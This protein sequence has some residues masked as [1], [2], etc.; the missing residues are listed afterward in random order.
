MYN[1]EPCQNKGNNMVKIKI[2]PNLFGLGLDIAEINLPVEKVVGKFLSLNAEP[3]LAGELVAWCLRKVLDDQYTGGNAD[4]AWAKRYP[5]Y[6][7]WLFEGKENIP[8]GVSWHESITISAHIAEALTKFINKVPDDNLTKMILP[9]L[10]I[11]RNYLKRHYNPEFKGFGLNTGGKYRGSPGIS[12]DNR[13]T[14]WAMMALWYLGIEDDETNEI[15]HNAAEFIANKLNPFTLDE[16]YTLTYA[17]FHK[18]LS[19]K[20]LSSVVIPSEKLRHSALKR[21]EGAIIDKYVPQCGSWDPD[22]LLDDPKI[23]IT[24]AL[25][26]LEPIQISSC[27]DK[28]CSEVLQK[29]LDHMCEKNLITLDDKTMA[30]PFYEGGEPDIGVTIELLWCLVKNRDVYKPKKEVM[31]K[32][33]NFVSD[34]S[35][36]KENLG[37]AY[38][39]N[40]S[41]VLLLATKQE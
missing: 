32:M 37:F 24:N 4:G 5:A 20:G 3:K 39:W 29:A 22:D 18:L 40:L 30:L 28:E 31:K 7:E 1:S 13:H 6:I 11:L 38:S 26:V 36:Q 35:S 17:A 9:R 21:I 33:A 16:K 8:S 14:V 12:V 27:I 10:N 2:A 15:L 23:H 34:P 41:S 25:C 19:T